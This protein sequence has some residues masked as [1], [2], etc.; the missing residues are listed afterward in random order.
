MRLCVRVLDECTPRAKP[1]QGIRTGS[2]LRRNV[3][4]DVVSDPRRETAGRE[5]SSWLAIEAAIEAAVH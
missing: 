2:A 1:D 5:A 3:L 4:G